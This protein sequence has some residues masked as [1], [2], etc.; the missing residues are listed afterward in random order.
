[1]KATEKTG[2]YKGRTKR[3]SFTLRAGSKTLLT[4]PMKHVAEHCATGIFADLRSVSLIANAEG[5]TIQHWIYG[6]PQK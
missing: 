6:R 5:K 2:S 3:K 1:M 4:T